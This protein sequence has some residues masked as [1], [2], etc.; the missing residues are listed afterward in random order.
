[1][2][3]VNKEKKQKKKRLLSVRFIKNIIHQDRIV[4][5]INICATASAFSAS[6]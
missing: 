1:M 2:S 6:L 3:W 5:W 4:A